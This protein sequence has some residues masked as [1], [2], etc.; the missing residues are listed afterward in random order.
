[1]AEKIGFQFRGGDKFAPFLTDPAVQSLFLP[2]SRPSAP[3]LERQLSYL[4]VR[5]MARRKRKGKEG[6]KARD[7]KDFRGE[8]EEEEEEDVGR[9]EEMCRPIPSSQRL[10]RLRLKEEI[11]LT[12]VQQYRAGR[13]QGGET[14]FECPS[15]VEKRDTFWKAVLFVLNTEQKWVQMSEQQFC[16]HH[17]K[18]MNQG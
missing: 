18:L 4:R 5:G 6:R 2:L 14:R 17:L 15:S 7:G 9:R 1:M 11:C 12:Y 8:E 10:E 13:N 16:R 3:T